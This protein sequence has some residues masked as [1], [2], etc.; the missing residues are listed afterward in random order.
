MFGNLPTRCHCFIGW[1]KLIQSLLR[2][3]ASHQAGTLYP[4]YPEPEG[5]DRS[6]KGLTGAT[7]AIPEPTP[8]PALGLDQGQGAFIQRLENLKN[9][10]SHG[11]V[12]V[13]C[14]WN[15][16]ISYGILPILPLS[17]NQISVFFED[18]KKFSV[19]L[20]SLLFSTL[21]TKCCEYKI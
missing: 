13:N 6:Q 11:K 19:C 18:I 10:N 20:E 2:Y 12:M 14:L 5:P 16:V 15:F 4:L 17:L 8:S 21:S 3:R 7:G 1:R 9:G